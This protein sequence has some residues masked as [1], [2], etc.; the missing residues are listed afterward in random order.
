MKIKNTTEIKSQQKRY[1][2]KYREKYKEQMQNRYYHE[3][4]K[5]RVQKYDEYKKMKVTKNS[6]GLIKR[7]IKNEEY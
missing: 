2:D 3:S 1:Y 5:E 7:I 6:T 4:R